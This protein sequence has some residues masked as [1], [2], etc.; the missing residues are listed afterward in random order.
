MQHWCLSNA[1]LLKLHAC[2]A[3]DMA[4]ICVQQSKAFVIISTQCC[5][6]LPV[7]IW[8]VITNPNPILTVQILSV[9]ISS[10]TA[11]SLTVMP[12]V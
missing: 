2:F 7:K 5:H 4:A 6:W 3:S 8:I 9:Q 11:L 10:V 12:R 1:A